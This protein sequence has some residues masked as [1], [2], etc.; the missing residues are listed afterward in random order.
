MAPVIIII[1]IIKSLVF[2][3]KNLSLK[4][5]INYNRRFTLTGDFSSDI[6]VSA[7]SGSSDEEQSLTCQPLSNLRN[8]IS[9]KSK[10]YYKD[11]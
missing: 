5:L 4:I 3:N 7:T 9:M 1:I 6:Y 10:F 8:L 11:Y 2:R